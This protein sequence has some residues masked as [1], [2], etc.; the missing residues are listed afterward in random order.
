MERYSENPSGRVKGLG[1]L[2]FIF[3]LVIAVGGNLITGPEKF[4]DNAKTFFNEIIEAM[5][6]EYYYEEDYTYDDNEED[7]STP[8][9]GNEIEDYFTK[10][11]L[12]KLNFKTHGY[13]MSSREMDYTIN[14]IKYHI[15]Y[16]KSNQKFMLTS[17]VFP[18]KT[19]FKY[20]DVTNPWGSVKVESYDNGLLITLLNDDYGTYVFLKKDLST[21]LTLETLRKYKPVLASDGDIY[22]GYTNTTKTD[23]YKYDTTTHVYQV[24]A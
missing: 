18:N 23:V 11:N 24:V 6:E 20:G 14:D 10:N 7:D 5:E 13:Y 9:Y 16:D 4:I 22:F 2:G 12:S 8:S 19:F 17:E 15:S 3:F 1:K 21:V